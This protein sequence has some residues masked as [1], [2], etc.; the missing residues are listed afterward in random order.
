MDLPLV[1]STAYAT[2]FLRASRQPPERV[3]AG[4]GLTEAD[5]I[6]RPFLDYPT[7]RRIISNIEATQPDPGWS[8]RIGERLHVSSHGPLGFAALSAPTL[9]DALRVMAEYY[10]VRICTLSA[11]LER[12]DGRLRFIMQDR[13]GDTWY[14]RHTT[15]PT[16]RVLEALLET[17]A[18][19]PVGEYVTISF[20]WAA[21]EYVDELEALYGA[22]CEFGADATSLS[23]PASWAHIPSPLYDEGSYRANVAKCRQV[24]AGLAPATDAAARVRDLLASHFDRVRLGESMGEAPPS[25]AALATELHTSPRTLIRRLKRQGTSYRSL[26]E[27]AQLDCADA[28]LGQAQLTV[29][30]VGERLGYN[31]PANFGRAF[32]KST[33]VTPAAWRRG[34]R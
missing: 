23:L 9:G 28:L 13:T 10:P 33:G 15:E 30:E 3:L 11:R 19:H 12:A 5:L 1:T 20:P 22:P 8:A 2:L 6:N 24:I 18:G 34:R 4:T 14:A 21:P 25:L 32:R 31:D 17:I 27:Q 16:M 7:M 29:A 26:L